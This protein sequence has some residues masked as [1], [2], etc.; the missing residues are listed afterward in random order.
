MKSA[1]FIVPIALVLSMVTQQHFDKQSAKSKLEIHATLPSIEALQHLSL[2]YKSLVADYYWLKTIN[3]FGDSRRHKYNYPNLI[4]LTRRTLYLDPYFKTAYTFAGTALTIKRLDYTKSNDL[5]ERGMKYRPDL[6]ELPFYL[7]FNHYY[8][9]KNYLDASK[10]LMHAATIEG[11]P[12][13]AGMLGMRL[14]AEANS[15]ELGLQ[16]VETALATIENEEIREGYE[17][18]KRYLLLEVHLKWLNK[19]Q[20][21]FEAQFERLPTTIDEL[22]GPGLLKELPQEPFGG[23]YQIIDGEITTTSEIERLHLDTKEAE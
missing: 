4:A 14:A 20:D 7:G 11:A 10:M 5:L 17:E 9:D 22:I 6:W 1:A 2:T 13:F 23:L 3:E 8:F 18:R 21:R 15:P 19:T 12:P 16:F